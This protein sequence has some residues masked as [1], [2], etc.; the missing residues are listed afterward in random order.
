MK[1][2]GL[3]IAAVILAGLEGALYWSN[4]H[5]PAETAEASA[6]GPPKIL[7]LK[8][9]D[10]NKLAIKDDKGND[11]A[12]MKD[13]S[14]NWKITA[15]QAL[16]ADD[17]AVS[18]LLAT[19]SS[20][21]SDR[22]VEEKA[23]N[24]N[25]YGLSSPPLQ[26]DIEEKDKK[27]QKLLIGDSTP[28]GNLYAKLDGDPRVFT[29]S[30]YLKA[31]LDKTTDDLRDKRLIT[32]DPDKVSKF[33]VVA[34]NEDLEFG[35]DKDAWQIVKPAPSRADQGE[36]DQLVRAVTDARMVF[37][38]DEGQQK[39]GA[40]FAAGT[41]IG[42]AKVTGSSG[43]QELEV[44]KDKNEYYA[45][46]SLL[47]GVYRVAGTVGVD[48]EKK[49]DEFRSK[50]LFD[51]GYEDPDKVEL[52]EGSKAY[53]LTKGGDDWWSGD[54]KK[55]DSSSALNFLDKL[56]D[57]S[58]SKFVDSG[59]SN[60]AVEISVKPHGGKT[61]EKVFIAKHG[62]DYIAKRENEPALY[63][64]DGKTVDDLEKAAADM[65]PAETLKSTEK[66]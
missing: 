23:A 19:V 58:A 65:K 17:N 38:K 47:A 49:P 32:I 31:S 60:P 5:K 20:L 30:S 43:T 50:K 34:K 44:R 48:M 25:Q 16:A 27:A 56:R 29:I 14:G 22:L 26:V 39:V 51:F 10:I 1:I 6:N 52:H 66:K 12:L 61:A 4:H 35:R 9:D 59:F 8:Q 24:L 46:S 42:I 37:A 55:L 63:Q 45:K 40:A 7:S 18:S 62:N 57:L 21:S 36:A 53:Y 54:G 2:R 33:E 28:T 41:P 13:G 15:P 11:V 64:L 3:V